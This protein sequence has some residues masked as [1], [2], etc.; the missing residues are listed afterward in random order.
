MSLTMN[1][2]KKG[3]SRVSDQVHTHHRKIQAKEFRYF[4]R[5]IDLLNGTELKKSCSIITV[6][7]HYCINSTELLQNKRMIDKYL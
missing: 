4:L 3:Q 7:D 1:H 6:I 5:C 2:I